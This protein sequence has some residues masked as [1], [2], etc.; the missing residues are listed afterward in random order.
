MEEVKNV[1]AVETRVPQALGT[2]VVILNPLTKEMSDEIAI[3]GEKLPKKEQEAYLNKQLSKLWKTNT[4][5]N[6][7]ADCVRVKAGDECISGQHVFEA[8]T[9]TPNPLYLIVRETIFKAKW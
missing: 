6:V 4:I 2:D 7:G 3:V 8:A 5:V 1:V 9:G